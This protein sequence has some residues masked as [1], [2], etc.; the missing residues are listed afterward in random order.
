MNATVTYNVEKQE[1]LRTPY[2]SLVRIVML[3]EKVATTTPLLRFKSDDEALL[4]KAYLQS[5]GG[6]KK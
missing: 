4:F 1:G 3:D 5:L 6:K 2:Y